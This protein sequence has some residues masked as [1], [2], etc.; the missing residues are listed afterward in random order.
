M[1][2][3]L[4]DLCLQRDNHRCRKCQVKFDGRKGLQ[5]HHVWP[6]RLSGPDEYFNL[7]CL[8]QKCHQEWHRNEDRLNILW[9]V[10]RT[11]DEF[12]R[13]LRGSHVAE[14]IAHHT[15]CSVNYL[16]DLLKDILRSLSGRRKKHRQPRNLRQT[17]LR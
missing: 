9:D 14:D 16:E 1:R 13:W 12:F 17:S 6:Q 10:K 5:L 15:D 8:C 3:T 4:R 7:I 11:R 2:K